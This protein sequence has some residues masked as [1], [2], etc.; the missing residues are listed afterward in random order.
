MKWQTKL[1]TQVTS[2]WVR[3]NNGKAYSVVVTL[4]D[5]TTIELRGEQMWLLLN[6]SSLRWQPRATTTRSTSSKASHRSATEV[7][8]EPGQTEW[9]WD[10]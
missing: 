5:D 7:S 6:E 10:G 8:H 2:L 3:L 4:K 1:W 9:T